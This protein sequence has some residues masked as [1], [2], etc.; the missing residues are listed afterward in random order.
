MASE[1]GIE[2]I[3]EKTPSSTIYDPVNIDNGVVSPLTLTFSHLRKSRRMTLYRIVVQ[4]QYNV[5]PH[6]IAGDLPPPPPPHQ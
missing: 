4:M 5:L 3:E 2:E 1:A 6:R